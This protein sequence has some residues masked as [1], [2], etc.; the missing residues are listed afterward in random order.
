MD[1][2]PGNILQILLKLDRTKL[3]NEKI[4]DK[5]HDLNEDV[6][7]LYIK[8]TKEVTNQPQLLNAGTQEL[9]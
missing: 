7:I 3:K 1:K 2:V 5:S 4:D 9:E 6:D 8:K